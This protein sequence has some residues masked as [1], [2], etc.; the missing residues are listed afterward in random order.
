MVEEYC[1]AITHPVGRSCC[2]W[3]CAIALQ[4]GF[5]SEPVAYTCVV[6][7][8]YSQ[9]R[10][11]PDLQERNQCAR[12][13]LS[14]LYIP[15]PS[16]VILFNDQLDVQIFLYMFISIIYMFREFKCSSSGD[17]TVSIR[18]LISYWYN[19]VSWWWALECSKHVENWN[20]HIKKIIVCQV[21]H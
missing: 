1:W 10:I 18:Y 8:L 6:D 19:W 14:L 3:W 16:D 20:K 4:F 13:A 15:R 9:I 11:A 2:S 5:Q 21:G 12:R 17:S 7:H